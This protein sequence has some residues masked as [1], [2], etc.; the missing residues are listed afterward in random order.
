MIRRAAAG[1]LG[2]LAGCATA[3][4]VLAPARVL[5]PQKIELDV[6]VAYQAPLDPSVLDTARQLH[7]STDDTLR[8]AVAYALAPPGVVP[9][10]SGRAGL[11]AQSEGSVAL[12]GRTLRAGARREFVHA[13]NFTLSAGLAGR[14][15]FIAG[16]DDAI[17]PNFALQRSNVYGGELGVVAGY[18]SRNIYDAYF[19]LRAAYLHADATVAASGVQ[20]LAFDLQAHRVEAAAAVGVRVGFGRIAATVELDARMA[21]SR[22][23]RSGE[24]LEALTWALVPAGALSYRF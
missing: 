1:A 23:G 3:S 4:P 22:G 9:S 13:G 7:P 8:A 5:P 12:I 6:G 17:I 24:G 18:S 20:P 2:L 15:A 14:F 10:V 19:A 16:A 11:G 21:W